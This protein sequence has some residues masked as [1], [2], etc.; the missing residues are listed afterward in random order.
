MK[1]SAVVALVGLTLSVFSIVPAN[2]QATR[3]W[4]SGVGD[5][6]NLCSRTAPCKTFAGAIA[7]TAAGGEINCLDPGGFGAVIITKSITIDCED[8][9]NGGVLVQLVDG[10]KITTGNVTLRGLDLN[11][12]G[13]GLY[14]VNVLGNATVNIQKSRIY[15]FATGGIRLASG[16]TL[17]VANTTINNGGA[18][19][20]LDGAGGAARMTLRDV[21]I[22]GNS[23]NGLTIQSSGAAVN[24]LIDRTT[25]ASNGGAGIAVSGASTVLLGGSTIT[26]NGTGLS[27]SGGTLYSFKNNQIGGNGVDGTPIA[28]FPGPGG[29]LQ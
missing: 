25:I 6:A 5:D 23:G 27:Q 8:T 11:G 14:G 21:V 15:G 7:S 26:G 2:A 10:I 22:S 12:L 3:T 29:A 1:N 9:S 17:V 28:A 16:G 18:G 20:V 24:A 4:V 19:I 13:S